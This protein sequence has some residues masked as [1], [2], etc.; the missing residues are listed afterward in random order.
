MCGGGLLEGVQE[1]GLIEYGRKRGG[2]D[3]DHG[4]D[5]GVSEV[6]GHVEHTDETNRGLLKEGAVVMVRIHSYFFSPKVSGHLRS[7]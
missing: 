2:N 1:K 5:Q 4:G 3:C 7:S 6:L